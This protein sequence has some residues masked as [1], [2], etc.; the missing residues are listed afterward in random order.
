[1]RDVTL[2]GAR[3]FSKIDLRSGYQQ[4]NMRD[5]DILK[6]TFGTR[7]GHYVFL[8]M[9]FGL[10]NALAAL[11]LYVRDLTPCIGHRTMLMEDGQVIAYPFRQLKVHEKNYHMHDLELTATVHALKIWRHYLYDVLC[12]RWLEL[13]KDYDITIFYQPGK[14]NM[15]ADALS[16]KAKSMG[17]LAYLHVVERLL[18]MDIQALVNRFVR[19]DVSEPSRVFAC[20]MAQSSLSECIKARQ[21]NDPHLMVFRDTVH[22]GGSKEVKIGNDGVM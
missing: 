10:T 20:V 6:T 5:S 13:L 7:Y 4:L 17:N 9:S 19:L 11:I 15:L 18:V 1:M 3:V 8:V 14:S 22:Q 16:R 21:L 12:E 2:Q